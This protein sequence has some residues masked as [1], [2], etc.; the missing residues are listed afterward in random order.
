MMGTGEFLDW[1]K[2]LVIKANNPMQGVNDGG[3]IYADMVNDF[4]KVTIYY[5]DTSGTSS[6]HDT[7]SFDFNFNANCAHLQF[8][9]HRFILIRLLTHKLMTQLSEWMYFISRH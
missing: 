1:Y 6:E 2:G 7:L 5:R 3:I 4:S 9:R 8:G